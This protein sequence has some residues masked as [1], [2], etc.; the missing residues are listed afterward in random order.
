MPRTESD[1]SLGALFGS[2]AARARTPPAS[3]SGAEPSSAVLRQVQFA[4]AAPDRDRSAA[5]PAHTMSAAGD[6]SRIR[7]SSSMAASSC[8]AGRR[9]DRRSPT[10]VDARDDGESADPE[11]FDANP[12][13]GAACADVERFTLSR[14]A[15]VVDQADLRRDVP[16][17]QHVRQQTAHL[18]AA[19]DR[20][21]PIP[22]PSLVRYCNG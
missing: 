9:T 20:D 22:E 17:R 1:T 16:A 5:A 2:S 21:P 11:T 13:T 15:V 6:R 3:A 10:I 8:Q 19:D 14:P 12:S 7:F 4:N 18:A